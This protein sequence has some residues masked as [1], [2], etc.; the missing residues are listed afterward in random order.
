MKREHEPMATKPA[1]LKPVVHQKLEL[2]LDEG[3][4]R[5]HKFP[6]ELIHRLRE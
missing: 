4:T 2:D 5:V 3:A 1:S 6:K